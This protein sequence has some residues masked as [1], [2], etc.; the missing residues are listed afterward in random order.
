[1]SPEAVRPTTAQ[2]T[3]TFLLDERSR[4]KS[5]WTGRWLLPWNETRYSR[6]PL[7]HCCFAMEREEPAN[8]KRILRAKDGGRTGP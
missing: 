2:L 4:R 8:G 3:A 1:V 6:R 7:D 5:A